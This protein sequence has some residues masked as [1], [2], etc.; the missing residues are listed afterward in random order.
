MSRTREFRDKQLSDS[1]NLPKGGTNIYPHS[2]H[3]LTEL[4]ETR[5]EK[6]PRLNASFAKTSA[7]K[8]M[9]CVLGVTDILRAMST[10]FIRFEW[11]SGLGLISI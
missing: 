8:A 1:H 5:Y 11:K 7:V 4:A 6:S 3:F 10:F 9:I 2:L